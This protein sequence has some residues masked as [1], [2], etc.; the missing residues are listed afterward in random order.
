MKEEDA[1]RREEERRQQLALRRQ[2]KETGCESRIALQGI[3]GNSVIINGEIY[4]VGST[5]HGAKLLKIGSNYVI[6]ECKG[7]RFRKVLQ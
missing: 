5:V 3:V 7:R 2:Q 1:L 4:S 6:G